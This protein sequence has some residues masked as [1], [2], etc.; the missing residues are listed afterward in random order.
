MRF[1]LLCAALAAAPA[2]AGELV[3]H[4]GGD[5]VR[6]GEG[7]CTSEAVLGR[8]ETRLHPHYKAASAVVQGQTF[9]ACWRVSGH[10]VHLIYEDGDQGIVPVDE[11][12]PELTA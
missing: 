11:L 6:L 9:T 10:A 8:I 5:T 7:P 12:K 1:V 4:Q 2:M 3:A